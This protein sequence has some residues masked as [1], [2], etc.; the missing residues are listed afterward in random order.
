MSKTIHYFFAPH[1]P[2]VYLG[3]ERLLKLAAQYGAMIWARCLPTP[4][5]CRWPS[6]AAAPGLPPAGT[7]ALVAT[8]RPADQSA[9][10][11]LPG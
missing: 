2:W 6:G 9:A 1:S 3:H 8:P 4:A 11:V 5:A 10:E 7:G